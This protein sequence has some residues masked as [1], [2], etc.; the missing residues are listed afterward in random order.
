MNAIQA[1]VMQLAAVGLSISYSVTIQ[2]PVYLAPRIYSVPMQAFLMGAAVG[3]NELAMRTLTE[4]VINDY[5]REVDASPIM[6][7]FENPTQYKNLYQVKWNI[8]TP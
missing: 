7:M 6:D 3:G 2:G 5:N 4:L 8:I 1:D